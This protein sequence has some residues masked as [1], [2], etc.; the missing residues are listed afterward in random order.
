MQ[1]MQTSQGIEAFYRSLAVSYDQILVVEGDQ[2][3][4]RSHYLQGARVCKPPP[5]RNPAAPY[6]DAPKGWDYYSDRPG[7]AALAGSS[8]DDGETEN[9]HGQLHRRTPNEPAEALPDQ[10]STMEAPV[11]PDQLQQRLKT[12]LATVLRIKDTSIIDVDR[13]FVELG[14]DS[15]LGTALVIAINKEYGTELSNITV[16]DYPTVRELTL[17][18]VKEIKNLPSSKQKPSVPAVSAP[19]PLA[20]SHFSSKRKTRRGRM[21]TSHQA[22]FHDKIAIIGMSGR[23]PQANNLQEYWDNLGE[24]RNSIVEVPPSR[25]DVHRYYDP[26]PAHND[27]TNSEWLGALDDIDC[28]DPLFF[29]ISPQEAGYIDPHHRLFLEESYKAFEDAGYSSSMLSNKKCGV[30]LGISGNEYA[31]LLSKNGVLAAPVTSNHCA[32]AAA[33]IAYY[34]NFK[35]PAISVG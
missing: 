26:D 16:F 25:W 22:P 18:L 15:F 32:I 7:H 21:I 9:G 11:S 10:L 5:N 3:K 20:G 30:Y 2:A 34:L 14:L 19:L 4:I 1:P 27:R 6:Q 13:A 33:R 28:F 8:F 24:G 23:Y 12:I 35:G 31:L 29:R 17:C